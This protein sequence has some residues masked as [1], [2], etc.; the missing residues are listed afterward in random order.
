MRKQLIVWITILLATLS[1]LSQ[2]R[3][4]LD[5]DIDS[6]V[7]D[8]GTLAMLY[9]LHKQQIINLLGIIVTSDDPYA[10]LCVSAF[11]SFYK[12]SRLPV[13]FLE[14]QTVL[15]NHSRYTRQ[16]S[17]EFPHTLLS[18]Q[19]ATTSVDAYRKLLA[20]SPDNSVIILT[21]G[22]LSS[23]QKL[24]QSGPDNYSSLNGKELTKAKVQNWYCMGGEFP[25]GKEANFSRPDPASTLY[26][27]ANWEK[28][29]VFCGWEVGNKIVTGDE[30]IKKQLIPKHP[31]YRAYELYNN[32]AGRASWDQVTAL[33][34]TSDASHYF[35]LDNAGNCEVEPDGSNKWLPG[36]KGKQYIV[37][38]KPNV[39]IQEIAAHI[40]RL[41]LE[42]DR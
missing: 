37:R 12:M 13:G 36:V 10:P 21:I 26:C 6:D 31:L 33:L 28:E 22:H 16:I 42:E 11:N 17:E 5:T 9:N 8:A 18:L 2:Q 38:F 39:N 35:D 19:N 4:I 34:L 7:D 1:A 20:E 32:F 27:L 23:L 40:T 15:K 41:M 25:E 29:V 24:L 3:V 14:G 30:S